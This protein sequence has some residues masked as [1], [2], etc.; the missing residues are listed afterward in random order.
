ML[1]P[2]RPKALDHATAVTRPKAKLSA[3]MYP[4]N[5]PAM[6]TRMVPPLDEGREHLTCQAGRKMLSP[7]M[8]ANKSKMERPPKHTDR[9]SCNV[10][11]A[12]HT[13]LP[14]ACREEDDTT[15]SHHVNTS[16]YTIRRFNPKMDGMSNHEPSSTE[17][18]IRT[19]NLVTLKS[20]SVM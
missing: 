1:S 18:C 15:A 2:P 5:Q 4:T 7:P 8:M 13:P 14:S 19:S 17:I 16:A 20:A 11:S 3:P 9:S 6:G 12:R 10:D